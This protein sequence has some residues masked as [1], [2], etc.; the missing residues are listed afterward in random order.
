MMIQ[1]QNKLQK[2]CFMGYDVYN[3]KRK[4]IIIENLIAIAMY[5]QRIGNDTYGRTCRVILCFIELI[6]VIYMY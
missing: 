5:K 4:K 6:V 2:N 1:Q 3:I